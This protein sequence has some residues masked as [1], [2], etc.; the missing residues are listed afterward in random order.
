MQ[1]ELLSNTFLT[2][3]LAHGTNPSGAD[4]QYILL[5]GASEAQTAAYSAAPEVTVISNTAEVQAV[6]EN[7]LN[8]TGYNFWRDQITTAGQ[9][10]SS[11]KASVM[12]KIDDSEGVAELAVADPTLENAGIIELELQRSAAEVLGKD[13]RIQ[14]MQLSPA[15]KLKV[16]VADT[17][18]KSLKISLR[19]GEE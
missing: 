4:Y 7:T 19:L 9:L 3:R 10:T 16:N 1:T 17:L 5:P 18:G 14:V 8:L 12:L 13:E 11:K 6:H 2:L 15:V